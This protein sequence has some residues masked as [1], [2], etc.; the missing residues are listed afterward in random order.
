MYIASRLLE[1]RFPRLLSIRVESRVKSGHGVVPN[2]THGIDPKQNREREIVVVRLLYLVSHPIQYQAPLLRLIAADPEVDLFVLFENLKT[3]GAYDDPGFGRRLEWD[4]P[5]T[6]GYEH[7]EATSERDITARLETADVLW[8]HGWDSTLKKRALKLANARNVP[9]LMR[10]ENNQMSMPDG[11]GLRGIAKRFYLNR[12][13]RRCAGFLCIG[14]DNRQ[15]YADHGVV[16]AKLFSLPYVVDNRFFQDRVATAMQN[17]AAFRADLGLEPSCPVILYAGKLQPRKHPLT[18]LAAFR[19][20]DMEAIGHPYLLY[21]GDGEQRESLTHL[22][23]DMG[24]RVRILG[25]RNQTELPAFY[26]LA[27][28]FVLASEREPWGLAVNEAMNGETAVIVSD[29]CGCAVDLIDDSCGRVIA[30]GQAP[31][32]RHALADVLSDPDALAKMGENAA[33][34]ISTWGLAEGLKG[35]KHAL[36]K[37]HA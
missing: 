10:G 16:S 24:D 26:D 20:L 14:S 3:V 5:L 21:V 19:E 2:G 36:S 1:Q 11:A 6:E 34:R 33:R 35:L 29:Q 32:L 17:R 4:V 28:V 15:Y 13:F 12:I 27:D 37:V 30:A 23:Q 8:V 25:F 22:S 7:G 31:A 18:L 9:V